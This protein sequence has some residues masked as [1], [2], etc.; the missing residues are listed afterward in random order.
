MLT[1]PSVLI[2][3]EATSALDSNSEQLIQEALKRIL[4]D[5]T[6]IIIAH[7]LS[8]IQ[9]VDRIVALDD[10]RVVDEGNHEELSVRCPMYRDLAQ[11]QF[12]L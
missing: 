2:L 1:N 12:L 9:H 7:R 11:K 4:A 8:T 10:G 6:A 3:D 5:K